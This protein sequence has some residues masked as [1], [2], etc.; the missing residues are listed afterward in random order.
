MSG[1]DF[2]KVSKEDLPPRVLVP[3]FMSVFMNGTSS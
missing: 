3:G 1:K 2:P